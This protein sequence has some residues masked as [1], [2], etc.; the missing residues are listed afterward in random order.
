MNLKELLQP[1]LRG[2]LLYAEPTRPEDFD[3]LFEV[4]RDPL[5]WEQHPAAD[6]WKPEVFRSFFEAALASSGALTV[7]E[8]ATGQVIGSSRYYEPS[9]D[10][11]HI[12]I[13]YTFLARRC[14]GGSF[15]HELKALMLSYAF[16][17]VDRVW[18]HIGINN[19]RSRRAILAVGGILDRE[20]ADDP[21]RQGQS[22]AYYFIDRPHPG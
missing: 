16:R 10:G 21:Q 22:T 7:F 4:A 18:F 9:P 5:I 12:A 20:V 19:V 13:G 1:S 17:F 3:A 15:N 14:W 11:R 2:D 8:A 6:R